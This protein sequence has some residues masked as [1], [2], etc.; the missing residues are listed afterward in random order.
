MFKQT[1]TYSAAV[2][3]AAMMAM[4]IAAAQNAEPEVLNLTACGPAIN[5]IVRTENVPTVSNAVAFVLVPNAIQGFTV[6]AGASRCIKVL[7]TA[8]A[9]CRGPA[10]VGDFCYIRAT[11]N[12]VE[13]LP[14]GAGF[15]T[16]VSEDPTE[17]AHAYQWVRR[18]GAG[19]QVVRIERRVGNAATSFLLDDWS[20]DVQIYN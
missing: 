8:K 2:L 14:Q 13:M 18:V 17:N 1:M 12:G 10:A 7:F 19:N 15:R 3:A 11:I 16:F 20:F 4:P 5:S 9:A 6:P